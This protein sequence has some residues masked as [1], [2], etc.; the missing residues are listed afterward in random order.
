MTLAGSAQASV[1]GRWS[2]LTL[3]QR[4]KHLLRYPLLNSSYF[5]SS[6]FSIQGFLPCNMVFAAAEFVVLGRDDLTAPGRGS[7]LVAFQLPCHARGAPTKEKMNSL[8]VC[9]RGAYV[10]C[11]QQRAEENCGWAGTGRSG[12][13]AP[14]CRCRLAKLRVEVPQDRSAAMLGRRRQGRRRVYELLA[15]VLGGRALIWQCS[16]WAGLEMVG[17]L[18]YWGLFVTIG[19]GAQG[20][21]GGE[22]RGKGQRSWNCFAGG[23]IK[24][25]RFCRMIS[26]RLLRNFESPKPWPTAAH[27]ST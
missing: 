17:K 24:A 16:G 6:E 8:H 2:Q 23:G 14:Q 4:L 26:A 18:P 5:L 10:S 9:V 12:E 15:A 20:R 1:A 25:A 27:P 22:G 13:A 7:H 3:A 19:G 21:E 11:R